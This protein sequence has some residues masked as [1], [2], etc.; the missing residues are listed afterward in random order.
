MVFLLSGAILGKMKAAD[1][2]ASST[3]EVKLVADEPI[4]YW[5]RTKNGATGVIAKLY[6]TG[7]MHLSTS[8]FD[9]SAMSDWDIRYTDIGRHLVTAGMIG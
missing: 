2:V 7:L 5:W 8:P 1:L 3:F 6:N 4:S 9:N